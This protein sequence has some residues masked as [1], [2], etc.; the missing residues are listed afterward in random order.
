MKTLLA[1]IAA[2]IAALAVSTA[3]ASAAIAQLN[4]NEHI[5]QDVDMVTVR[6]NYRFGGPVVAKY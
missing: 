6:L 1:G 4:H 5:C 3:G 2:A